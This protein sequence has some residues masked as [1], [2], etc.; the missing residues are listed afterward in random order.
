MAVQKARFVDQSVRKKKMVESDD[1]KERNDAL[2][3]TGRGGKAGLARHTQSQQNSRASGVAEL[4][5]VAPRNG[6][7]PARSLA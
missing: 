5:S 4:A 3:T 1:K 6:R 7:T 2:N